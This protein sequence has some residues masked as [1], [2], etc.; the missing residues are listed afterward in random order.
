MTVRTIGDIFTSCK[1]CERILLNTPVAT[2]HYKCTKWKAGDEEFDD[3]HLLTSLA[4]NYPGLPEAE[5]TKLFS[6]CRLCNL[7]YMARDFG[8]HVCGS[9]RIAPV[10][11]NSDAAAESSGSV[12][13]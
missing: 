5:F 11:D 13:V 10:P 7:V 4:M 3:G 2:E 8:D 9:R 12:E 6:R 1:R